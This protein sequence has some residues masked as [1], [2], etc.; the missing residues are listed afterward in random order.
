MLS[1]SLWCLWVP[2]A[3]LN[4]S[5]IRQVCC[6]IATGKYQYRLCARP[7]ALSQTLSILPTGEFGIQ[8][9]KIL[10]TIYLP[11]LRITS[12]GTKLKQLEGIRSFLKDGISPDSYECVV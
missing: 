7:N 8:M 3:V 12:G 1:A 6:I 10:N 2:P 5:N 4:D 9:S 11:D